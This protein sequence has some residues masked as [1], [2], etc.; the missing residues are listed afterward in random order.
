ME[1]QKFKRRIK[2]IDSPFQYRMIAL[3]LAVV[4]AGFMVFSAGLFL[5]YW[6]SYVSG[7]NLFKEIITLHKQITRTRTAQ[8]SGT[9]KSE[10]YTTTQDV[11]GVNR[12]E[13]VL[14]PIL[15]NNLAIMAFVIAVGIV[16]THRIA[17]PVY[18]V[19]K[20][21]DRV[22]AGEKGVRISL[23]KGDNFPALAEK[24]NALIER[25]ENPNGGNG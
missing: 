12:L 5:Y 7:D 24:V 10:T 9:G 11:P 13:L 18:R 19:E 21:I 22:L 23:R 20:E 15:I 17:G 3:F 25:I 2:V 14:P 6:G 1:R 4:V 16:S 8:E